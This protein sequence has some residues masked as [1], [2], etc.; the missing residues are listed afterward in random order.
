MFIMKKTIIA[1]MIAA[2]ML[3]PAFTGC[4]KSP[5]PES[6]PTNEA[7]TS[8]IPTADP[9]AVLNGEPTFPPDEWLLNEAWS[10]F[11]MVAEV[12]GI[13]LDRDIYTVKSDLGGID[14]IICFFA[15]EKGVGVSGHICRFDDGFRVDL[16]QTRFMFAEDWEEPEDLYN[17]AKN[18]EFMARIEGITVT[19]EDLVSYGC[20]AT[21]GNEYLEAVGACYASKLAELFVNADEGFHDKCYEA[22]VNRAEIKSDEEGVYLIELAVRPE[23][24]FAFAQAR[25]M[26]YSINDGSYDERF[27]GWF[28]IAGTYKLEQREDGSWAGGIFGT[29]DADDRR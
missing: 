3:L 27:F 18:A 8:D 7:T 19:P 24:I 20:T 1:V 15:E 17:E 25:E 14:S 16:E 12:H 11:S 21:S 2:L 26:D 22:A 28:N 5:Q 4:T 29:N 9:N 10:V 23:D 13:N 6:T